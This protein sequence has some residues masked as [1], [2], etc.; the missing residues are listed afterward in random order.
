MFQALKTHQAAVL[1]SIVA[2]LVCVYFLDPILSLI[3]RGFFYWTQYFGEVYVNRIY[4]QAAHL[5]TVNYAFLILVLVGIIGIV[6]ASSLPGALLRLGTKDSHD[7]DDF[8]LTKRGLISLTRFMRYAT[9]FVL[10][11]I[12]LHMIGANFTQLSLISSFQQHLRIIA[13]YVTEQEEEELV[14]Q[15]SLMRT[16]EDFQ[17]VS[18]KLAEVAKVNRV[19]LPENRIYSLWTL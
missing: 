12:V 7:D 15:W 18:K 17:A 2:S 19:S 5:E 11:P 13:P 1:C 14:S 6:V 8:E 10:L 16:K 3:G 4:A 9:L